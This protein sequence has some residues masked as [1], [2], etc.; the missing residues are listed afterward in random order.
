MLTHWYAEGRWD[1]TRVIGSG[2]MPSSHTACVSLAI[3]L[4]LVQAAMD[5]AYMAVNVLHSCIETSSWHVGGSSDNCVGI[6][7][8]DRVWNLCNRVGVLLS[9]K[10][11]QF[12]AS[13]CCHV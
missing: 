3:K 10:H 1:F 11:S 5:I 7:S 2:G 8:G 9:G 12:T 6:N 4:D 13:E